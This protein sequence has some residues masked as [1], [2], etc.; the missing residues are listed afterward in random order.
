M[1]PQS[2]APRL[3]HLSPC[4]FRLSLS[5]LLV[6]AVIGAAPPRASAAGCVATHR[7]IAE[8]AFDRLDPNAYAELRLLL[9]Q[10]WD[11][12]LYGA[13]FPDWGMPALQDL[14][15]IAHDTQFI[16]RGEPPKFRVA[17]MRS[18]K[19]A[20]EGA[21]S[22]TE[23][24]EA[25]AFLFGVIAHQ[26][27]DYPWHNAVDGVECFEIQGAAE[28]KTSRLDFELAAD[29]HA[30]G[31][32]PPVRSDTIEWRI[33][34]KAWAGVLD[35]YEALGV[36]SAVGAVEISGVE[37]LLRAAQGSQAALLATERKGLEAANLLDRNAIA[38][39]FPWLSDNIENYR[40]GGIE[41]GAYHAAQAWMQTWNWLTNHIPETTALLQPSQPTAKNGWYWAPVVV[42]L[43]PG[44]NQFRWPAEY[45]RYTLDGGAHVTRYVTT[46]PFTVTLEGP[47]QL[48]YYSVDAVG[49][50]QDL[51]TQAIKIDS[52]PPL[53]SLRV[54]E[55]RLTRNAPVRAT[56]AARD[57]APGS[58]IATFTLNGAPVSAATTL[59]PFWWSIDD[60]T[61]TARAEDAA[62]HVTEA[63][64]TIQMFATIESLRG[65]VERLCREAFIRDPQLCRNFSATLD[66]ANRAR[67][68][69][70]AG[71]AAAILKARLADVRTKQ[72]KVIVEQAA[73]LLLGDMGYAL[74]NLQ[75][76]RPGEMFLE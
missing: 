2:T 44:G 14:S 61:L 9:L 29:Q 62:G 41:D 75:Q 26:E 45:V 51:R 57:P 5:V 59:D 4:L 69:G 76:V 63:S 56:L 40:A 27:A 23:T 10:H 15:E 74:R 66:A 68:R 25:L 50:I 28:V 21:R 24:R 49:A 73:R 6:F 54:E 7:V 17:L 64:Q 1:T 12:V 43:N 22:S 32:F 71:T 3:R 38:K 33:P 8:R 67:G 72:G 52:R 30:L 48:A 16:K 65:T 70:D 13:V 39:K 31:H 60:A 34:D 36:G 42:W 46:A 37:A 55:P 19:T 20:F 47:A 35:G 58:G 18:L 11:T 53:V